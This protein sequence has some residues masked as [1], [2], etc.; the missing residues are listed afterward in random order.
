MIAPSME[1]LLRKSNLIPFGD[2]TVTN[3]PASPPI[4]MTFPMVYLVPINRDEVRIIKQNVAR[5]W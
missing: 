1:E 4:P 3:H 2:V 5:D